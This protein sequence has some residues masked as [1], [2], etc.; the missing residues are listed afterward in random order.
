MSKIMRA[1]KDVMHRSFPEGFERESSI[2]PDPVPLLPSSILNRA[3]RD[4]IKTDLTVPA[5]LEGEPIVPRQIH[6]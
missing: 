1:L 6:C 4:F 3:Q 5:S 2:Q